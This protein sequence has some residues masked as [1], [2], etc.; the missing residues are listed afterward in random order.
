MDIRS[1]LGGFCSTTVPSKADTS[2]SE[3]SNEE[4]GREPDV[5]LARKRAKY[6]HHTNS[7]YSR[8]YHKRW[9]TDFP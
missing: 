4:E 9:E 6:H 3:S 5:P 2:Q 7:T 1:F 8:K